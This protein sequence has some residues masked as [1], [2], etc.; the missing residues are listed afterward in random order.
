MVVD[1][2][3]DWQGVGK[4]GIPPER[5][6]PLRN[7]RQGFTRQHPASPGVAGHHLGIISHPP[8]I[9]HLQGLG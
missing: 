7:P 9:E 1:D 6:V 2:A 3:F 8:M 5:V 4:P